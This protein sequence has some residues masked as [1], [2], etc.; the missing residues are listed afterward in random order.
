MFPLKA[1]KGE[2]YSRNENTYNLGQKEKRNGII[3]QTLYPDFAFA[4]KKQG[5]GNGEN[6]GVSIGV[7][8]RTIRNDIKELNQILKDYGACVVSEISQG[9]HLRIEDQEKFSG[10]LKGLERQK[11]GRD[12]QNI[13]PSEPED[14]VRYIISKLLLA[15]LNGSQEIIDFL[16]WK[17]NCL[18]ALRL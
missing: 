10:F 5:Y 9:Y 18:S 16:T 6:L 17:K 3:K 2:L 11:K 13:I 1:E 14:R 7:S 8:S 12:F 15:S 4:V